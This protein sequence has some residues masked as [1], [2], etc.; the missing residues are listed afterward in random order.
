MGDNHFTIGLALL[1]SLVGLLMYLLARPTQ[2][3]VSAIGMTMFWV[4]LLAF[5]LGGGNHI[6][7][8]I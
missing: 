6:F 5:L 8:R 4:G 1:I 2:A 3:K 7:Y